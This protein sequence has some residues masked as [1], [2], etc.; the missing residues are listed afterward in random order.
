MVIVKIVE[1]EKE[2]HDAQAVRKHVFVHEQKI[3]IGLEIDEHEDE[4]IHFIAY[5]NKVPIGAAR[6]RSVENEAKVERVCVVKELRQTGVGR[7][8]M[9]AIEAYAQ[10]QNWL[11][12]RLHAQMEAVPFYKKLGYSV[13]SEPF[14]EAGI[15]HFAMKK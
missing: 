13:E 2:W 8:L 15:L 5:K 10:Q 3:P 12:I 7:D 1:T 14:K 6:V 9:K 4:A 11:P